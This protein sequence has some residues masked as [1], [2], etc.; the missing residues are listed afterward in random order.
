[1]SSG[2]LSGRLT[3][4]FAAACAITAANLYLNQPILPAIGRTFD[5][6]DTATGF[7]ATATQI[8]YA[9]GIV[10]FVPLGD[11]VARRRL[12]L[13][14]CAGTTLALAATAPSYPILVLSSFLLGALTPVPQI[15]IPF[16][17]GLAGGGAGRTVGVLQGGLLVGLLGARAYS[18][19]LA[20]A[21]SWRWVFTCSVALM[22][23]LSAL[24]WRTL[25]GEPDRARANHAGRYR[26]LLTSLPQLLR[27]PGV[28]RICLSGALV[29][30][31]FGAFWTTLTFLLMTDF[32]YGPAVA[33]L[34]GL[35]AAASALASPW[36]GR[37]A[38]RWGARPTQLVLL[39]VG[40]A[41]WVALWAG[42]HSI[43]WLVIGVIALDVAVW[44]NQVVN[45][46]SLFAGS[47]DRHTR[48]NAVYFATRF[49][50]IAAGSAIGAG[51]WSAAGWTGIVVL[52]ITALGAALVV[53]TGRR[54]DSG[55]K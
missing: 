22:I 39:A 23:A 12:I 35:V 5:V 53:L 48:L 31:C 44:G 28:T 9:L 38:D 54:A 17:V 18:G 1:M 10:A 55:E 37:A 13:A 30:V 8:G 49:A 52:G 42:R 40:L 6:G 34:F 21:I 45:Q 33:G 32:G 29:G 14:L 4:I 16:A 36:A 19:A 25:P 3:G 50:G 11:L 15:V 2:M 24:L 46:A 41:S 20:Q 7:V 51:V 26:A 47:K 27:V 43:P